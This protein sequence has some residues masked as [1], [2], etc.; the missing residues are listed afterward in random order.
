MD[1]FKNNIF[2]CA[3]ILPSQLLQQKL[4]VI[5]DNIFFQNSAQNYSRLLN[6]QG[7]INLKRTSKDIYTRFLFMQQYF[8]CTRLYLCYTEQM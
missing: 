5:L 7:D 2:S 4:A 1:S 3:Q 6:A 8:T